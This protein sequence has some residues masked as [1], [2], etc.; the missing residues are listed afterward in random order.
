MIERNLKGKL[1]ELA[2]YYPIVTVTGPRQAGKTTLCTATF[3]D[4]L[5]VSLEPLDTRE[6]ARTDPRGFLAEYSDGAVIDEVQNVSGLLS[7]LQEEVDRRPDPGRFIL[8]GSQHFGLVQD[9][10]QSLAGRAGIL[11]LFPPSL[12]EV[13]RFSRPPVGLFETLCTGA[14]PRIHDR[15]IPA[16][17]WLADYVTTYVQRD[18]RRILNI[19]DL[20]AFTT[21]MKLSAGRCGQELNTSTLSGDA[22]VSHNTVRAWLS[23]LEASYI[24]FRL[25]AWHRNVRKQTI[26]APKLHFFDSGLLCYLLGI[27]EPAQ[28]IHHPQRGAVFESWV[29]SEIFKARAHRGA[30]PELFHFRD[31]KGLE[32]DMVL[33]SSGKVVLVETKSG[34]TLSNDFFRSMDRL[35]DL[36]RENPRIPGEMEQRLVYGGETGQKR[37]RSTVVPWSRIQ[38]HGW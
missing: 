11:S 19:G 20:E 6:Y 37:S 15:N 33:E 36:I 7:Y 21:F 24:C 17:Q 28:L 18:V 23:V 29:A 16:R 14:Y 9:V 31:A 34:A 38:D 3:P 2:G 10:S 5:Y 1:L 25:P 26:K 32:V 35:G 8:T 13:R 30:R 12:D 22:G 27:H 4:K